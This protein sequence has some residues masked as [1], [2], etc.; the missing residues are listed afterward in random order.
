M[1]VSCTDKYDTHI[2]RWFSQFEE[3]RHKKWKPFF[4]TQETESI[5]GCFFFEVSR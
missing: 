5:L 4:V 3:G 1:I 2:M